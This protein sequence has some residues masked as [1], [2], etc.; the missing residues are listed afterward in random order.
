MTGVFTRVC[1]R[2]ESTAGQ[3]VQCATRT[4]TMS[5]T[6]RPRLP[7]RPRGIGPSAASLGRRPFRR[8]AKGRSPS[9]SGRCA[10]SMKVR[11]T[12]RVEA[13]AERF[14][15]GPWHLSRLFKKHVGASPT[16]VAQTARVQRAN[17][18]IDNT[19]AGNDRDC[20]RAVGSGSLR[21]FNAVF[22]AVYRRPPTAFLRASHPP[23]ASAA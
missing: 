6:T 22:A 9:L 23:M 18:A 14:G 8:P 4:A 15:I 1:A 5:N 20:A 17:R 19:D 12:T 10:S 7:P 21:R 13:L 16:Q 3:S 2:P 11:S